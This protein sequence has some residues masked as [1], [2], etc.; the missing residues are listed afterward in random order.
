MNKQVP[1]CN[2]SNV[3]L[4]F[5]CPSDVP[6]VKRL[7]TEWFPIEYPDNWYEEI[8]SS[9]QFFSLAAVYKLKI[10]GLIVAEIKYQSKCNRED[11]GLLSSHFPK[12]TEVA[13]ILTL[14][15]VRECRRNGIATLLLDSLIS[16]LTTN[17][18][19]S[20]C[21]AIYLHV[22]TTNMTAIRFYE[23]RNFHLHSYLP[24]YYSVHGIAKDGFSYALY[25]NGG[26]PP[27]TILDYIRHCGQLA[28]Q[29][30]LCSL[31]KHLVQMIGRLIAKLWPTTS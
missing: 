15:V 22:L 21:K 20:N 30:K 13:Y 10:I 27:W 4:R 6:E 14:G 2:D 12:N 5:L 3:Q 18:E 17:P 23:H 16:H 24:L 11:Q 9:Q 25:I 29:T 31:P 7:C 1:L 26:H 28:L 19:E 8:T